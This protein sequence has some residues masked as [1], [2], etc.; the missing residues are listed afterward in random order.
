MFYIINNRKKLL[1]LILKLLHFLKKLIVQIS[2]FLATI[3]MQYILHLK[4]RN[5]CTIRNIIK[6]HVHLYMKFDI[7]VF[8]S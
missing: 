5:V 1:Q 4:H 8:D 7:T 3:Y 6:F 2:Y